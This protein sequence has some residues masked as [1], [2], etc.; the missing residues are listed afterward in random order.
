MPAAARNS[1]AEGYR[2]VHVDTDPGRAERVVGMLD[3]KDARDDVMALDLIEFHGMA[4][5]YQW[6]TLLVRLFTAAGFEQCKSG[7]LRDTWKRS[8]PLSR[9]SF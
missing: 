9:N 2:S 7:A 5:R 8:A 1:R 3:I 4:W 6:E